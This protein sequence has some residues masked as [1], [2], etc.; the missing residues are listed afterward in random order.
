[1]PEVR[2]NANCRVS[3]ASHSAGEQIAVSDQDATILVGSGRAVLIAA[4]AAATATT[5]KG[6]SKAQIEADLAA[7]RA[8]E[9]QLQADLSQAAS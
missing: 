9:A 7:A 3:G 5:T 6:R 2:L 4:T 8:A 1:M